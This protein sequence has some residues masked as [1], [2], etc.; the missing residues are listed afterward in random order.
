VFEAL[1]AAVRAVRNARAEYGVE[2]ARR[3]PAIFVAADPALREALSQE[4]AVLAALARLQ[5]GAVSFEAEVPPAMAATP[6][7]VVALLVADGLQ[8]L[9]PVA[10]LA[11]PAKEV[12]R[13][14][15][16]ATKLQAELA[17][18]AARLAAPSFADKAPPAV[19]AKTRDS[20]AQL[21]QQLAA[22]E[23]KAATMRKLLEAAA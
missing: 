18:V 4:V 17:V 9:L 8:V 6:D 22:I 1:R 13:L 3:V 15:K 7:D 16:Q 10:G 12:A 23:A 5:P 11:D 14:A 2:P 20:A 19:L 21:T